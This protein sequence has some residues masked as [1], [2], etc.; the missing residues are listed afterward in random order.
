MATINRLSR[1]LNPLRI[2]L[3]AAY[4]L[5]DGLSFSPACRNP[6]PLVD[7]FRTFCLRP[8]T[9]GKALPGR[10]SAAYIIHKLPETGRSSDNSALDFNEAPPAGSPSTTRLEGA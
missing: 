7:A 2:Q 4:Y 8:G 5:V 6:L 10:S 9:Q 1:D 3:L